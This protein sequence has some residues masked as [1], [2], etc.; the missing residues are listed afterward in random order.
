MLLTAAM[1]CGVAKNM[2]SVRHSPMPCA[3]LARATAASS[4]VSA[5]VSTWSRRAA[6]TQLQV[7]G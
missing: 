3:P 6:S 5:L 4:G 2:C 7:G 1:R